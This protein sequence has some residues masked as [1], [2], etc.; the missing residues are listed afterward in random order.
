MVK[1][2]VSKELSQAQYRR[3]SAKY[4]CWRSDTYSIKII[5]SINCSCC[6]GGHR[7]NAFLCT[8]HIQDIDKYMPQNIQIDIPLSRLTDPIMNNLFVKP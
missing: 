1:Y 6:Q 8:D 4:G 2:K 7:Q 3:C 5:T